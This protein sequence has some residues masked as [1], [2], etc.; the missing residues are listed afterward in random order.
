MTQDL[1][2][3]TLVNF[4][5][6]YSNQGQRPW[7]KKPNIIYILWCTTIKTAAQ[8]STICN[9][10]RGEGN[11]KENERSESNW[12]TEQ[13]MSS[14]VVLVKKQDRP[15]SLVKNKDETMEFCIDYW[16][17]DKVIRK[18]AVIFFI[19]QMTSWIH[20]SFEMV[21]TLDLKCRLNLSLYFTIVV[22]I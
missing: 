21:P 17:L 11:G 14:P 16:K 7:L 20:D 10:L 4:L 9:T 2:Y 8:R 22:Q 15:M 19:T 1:S 13:T 6:K 5:N 12:R 3:I 18:E